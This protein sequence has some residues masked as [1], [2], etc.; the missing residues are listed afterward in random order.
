MLF[1]CWKS[2]FYCV[3]KKNTFKLRPPPAPFCGHVRIKEV[4]VY[5]SAYLG[6]SRP[7]IQ[8]Q[9]TA[10]AARRCPTSI[11]Q[12]IAGARDVWENRLVQNHWLGMKQKIQQGRP[13]SFV[14]KFVHINHRLE[15]S[16]TNQIASANSCSLIGRYCTEWRDVYWSTVT[17]FGVSV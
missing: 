11:N 4:I 9:G 2:Q 5:S 16:S 1:V 6:M 15:I 3:V 7:M 8:H 13:F 10:R 17:V 14:S 12:D